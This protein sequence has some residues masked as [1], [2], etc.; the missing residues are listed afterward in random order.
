MSAGQEKKKRGELK[1]PKGAG[2]RPF[3]L[4][5]VITLE[6]VWRALLITDISR[7]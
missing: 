7:I 1:L 6:G 5:E 4:Y 2:F 3:F